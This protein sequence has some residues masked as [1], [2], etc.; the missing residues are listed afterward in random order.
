MQ[1]KELT[2]S[3]LHA[4]HR[5]RLRARALKGLNSGFQDHEFLE[6]LL[7]FVIAIIP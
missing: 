4:G 1:D 3:Q 6:L 7:S 5:K 2:R